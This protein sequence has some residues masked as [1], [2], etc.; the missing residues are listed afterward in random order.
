MSYR[1]IL[2]KS[3][4]KRLDRLPDDIA[5]RILERLRN[6]QNDPRPADVKKLK[7]RTAWRVRIGDYRAIYE[8]HDRGLQ[9][10]VIAVGH[11]REVYR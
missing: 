2:P 11:R 6:L 4:Q 9:V 1:V 3:V 7:G 5:A 10:I 8:I